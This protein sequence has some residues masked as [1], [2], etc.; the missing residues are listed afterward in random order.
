MKRKAFTLIELLVVIAIIAILAAILFPVFAQAKEKAK[1]TQCLSNLNQLGKSLALYLSDHD[2]TYPL[3][4]T[5]NGSQWLYLNYHPVPNDWNRSDSDAMQSQ[6][7][8][9]WAN[10]LFAYVQNWA[11]YECPSGVELQLSG[12]NYSQSN[13]DEQR[14]RRIGYNFNGLLHAYNASGIANPAEL[15]TVWEGRGKVNTLGYGLVNP[16]LVCN[17]GVGARCLFT[18]ADLPQGG[19]FTPARTMWIH[20]KGVQA[21]F[22]DTHSKWRRVGAQ[23]SNSPSGGQPYTDWRV[24]PFTGY[25]ALGIPS[26]YWQVSDGTGHAFLFRP[27][28]DFRD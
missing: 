27:N 6:Y 20:N 13:W 17:A 9:F 8:M 11:V 14:P 15:I 1:Q 28:Y 21:S 7:G 5:N 23:W 4:F 18:P 16:F 12:V 2:D 22:A 19:M 3:S 24:D 25:Y 26:N 10:S